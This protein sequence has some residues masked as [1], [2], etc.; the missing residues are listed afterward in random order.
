MAVKNIS[1]KIENELGSEL[2]KLEGLHGQH[3]EKGSGIGSG[4]S[5]LGEYTNRLFGSPFQLLESVDRRFDSI[6][7]EV[8]NEY[9]RNFLLNSPIL[10]IKPGMPKYTGGSSQKGLIKGV[11]NIFFNTTQ[12][13]MS[14]TSAFFDQLVSATIFGQGE[15]LQK[16]MFGFRETYYEYMQHVN[17]M[18]HSVAVFLDLTEGDKF[19]SGTFVSE[20]NTGAKWAEFGTM[21]WKDY[22]M[23]GKSVPKTPW[24]YLK[25]MS[26]SLTDDMF[27]TVDGILGTAKAGVKGIF[28]LINPESDKTAGE[29]LGGVGKDVYESWDFSGNLATSD[30]IKDN[31][32]SVQ[33]MVEPIA[34]TESMDNTTE[35]SMIETAV[36]AISNDIGGEIA[37]ITNSH[38]DTGIIG[39]IAGILGSGV[40]TAMSSLSG[41]VQ[42]VAGGFVNNL[43]SGALQS[44]KGQKMI[45]PEIYKMSKSHMDYQ[46]SLTL[47]TPYGDVYNYYMNIIVPLLHL[48]ALVAP[49]MVTSNS[50][51][52]PFLVQSYIPGMCTCQL[53]II[54]Q[55]SIQ[56]N[57]STK[58]VSVNGFPLTIRVEFTIKELY[59]ALSISPANDPSSFLFNETLNDYMANLSGLAPSIDTY[60]KQR[61]NAF[62]NM[63]SYL[64]PEAIKNDLASGINDKIEDVFNPFIG[65]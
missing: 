30:V 46:F 45:Y 43:F 52:S 7:S 28:G 1:T 57:P 24:E 53:G 25:S 42:S 26:G 21:D 18:C 20:Q 22:R 11:K 8:G 13:G 48:I 55:M 23:M 65:R 64:S 39:D 9:L 27:S 61:I 3:P 60:T 59:N 49:R 15:K 50:V 32:T 31:I 37:F 38:A 33:F 34:F 40:D 51:T 41:L 10:H 19:P 58:H 6:N 16:R 36:D 17:Y 29:I 54:S 12:G 62:E 5:Y 47:T 44:I 14:L 56:K 63:N 4:Q 35:P 2:A